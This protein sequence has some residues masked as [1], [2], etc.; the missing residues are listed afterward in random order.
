MFVTV[1]FSLCCVTTIAALAIGVMWSR[2]RKRL[3]LRQRNEALLADS[4]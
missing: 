3:T 2:D 1:L 4:N